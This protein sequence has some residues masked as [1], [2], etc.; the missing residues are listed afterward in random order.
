MGRNALSILA[1][2]LGRSLLRSVAIVGLILATG[3][4][5][6]WRYVSAAVE[7][8]GRAAIFT[9]T[10]KDQ[11]AFTADSAKLRAAF[12]YLPPRPLCQ[13]TGQKGAES[14]GVPKTFLDMTPVELAKQVPELKHLEFAQSQDMLPMILQRVGAT[15]ADFFENF[16]NTTCTERVISTVDT[17]TETHAGYNDAKFDY[18]ALVQP[19]ADKTRLKEFRTNSKGKLARWSSRDAAVTIGFVSMTEHFHPDYQP[20]SHFR[21]LGREAVEGQNT[22]VVAFAQ[23]PEVARHVGEVEFNHKTAVV[24]LQGVAWIDP[25]SF[26]ILGLRTDIQQP[27]LNVGL[28]RETTEVEYSEVTFKEGGKTLWLPHDVTVSGRLNLYTF[29]NE[30]HYSDYRLFIVQTKEKEKGP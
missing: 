6:A 23:R 14:R 22:Y 30:H 5:A 10:G 9:S 11:I 27:E 25:A 1:R 15:V 26:R 16:S 29:H 2:G 19:G 12:L 28:R 18:V 13:V 24:L 7:P 3:P 21:Y 4:G 8:H 20:D 17:P